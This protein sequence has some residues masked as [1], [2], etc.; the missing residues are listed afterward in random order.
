MLTSFIVEPNFDIKPVG[1]FEVNSNC[2]DCYVLKSNHNYYLIID[3]INKG[4]L[5]HYPSNNKELNR[6]PLKYKTKNGKLYMRKF[7]QSTGH[8][9]GKWVRA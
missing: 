4:T 6:L 8:W 9:I 1:T 2:N 3:N 7:N 5:K